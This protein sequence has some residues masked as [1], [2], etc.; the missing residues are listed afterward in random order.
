MPSN[1]SEEAGRATDAQIR[2]FLEVAMGSCNKIQT[3]LELATRFGF[4][5]KEKADKIGDETFQV[6]KMILSFYNT[7]HK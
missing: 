1:I 4:K 7:L 2:Y 3:Q 6:Y 5:K